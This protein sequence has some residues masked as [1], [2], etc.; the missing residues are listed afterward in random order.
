MINKGHWNAAKPSIGEIKT[1]EQLD[2]GKVP[3]LN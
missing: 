2:F 1:D 3:E